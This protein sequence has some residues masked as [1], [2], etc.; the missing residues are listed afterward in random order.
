ME[1]FELD[2]AEPVPEDDRNKPCEDVFYLP[3]Q[4]QAVAPSPYMYFQE[5]REPNESAAKTKS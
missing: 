1:Y 3:M 2:H 5:E 4:G